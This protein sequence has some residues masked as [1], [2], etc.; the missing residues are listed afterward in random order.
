MS[1]IKKQFIRNTCSGWLAQVSAAVVG[2]IMLPYNL[3]HLGKDVYGISVIAVSAIAMLQ[4]LNLGMGPA[5]LR[6][7]SQAI[8]RKDKN[9]IAVISST[10]Q[11]I[12]GGLGLL[13]S[14]I[15]IAGIPWF[16]RFYEIAQENHHETSILL[17]C[18]AVT[19]FQGFHQVVFSSIVT[20]S[21][22]FDMIYLNSII[23]NWLRMGLLILFYQIFPPSLICLSMALILASTFN[24]LVITWLA[25]REQGR[26]IFFSS[27][28]VAL[29][30]FP[31]L[32]SFS[33]LIMIS[34]LFGT[35]AS[36]VPIMIIGKTMGKETVAVFYPVVL[37]ATSLHA[38]LDQ[39]AVSLVPIA[40]RDKIN[41][42]G[43]NL[44]RWA[45][46]LGQVVACIGYACICISVLFLPNVIRLWL[47]NDFVGITPLAIVMVCGYVYGNIQSIN[48]RLAL[49]TATI[50]PYVCSDGIIAFIVS[51]GTLIGTV[52]LG[53]G[54][55]E[56]C[57]CIALARIVCYTFYPSWVY[58]RVFSYN[59]YHYFFVIYVK[60]IIPS[61]LVLAMLWLIQYYVFRNSLSI[62]ISMFEGILFSVL[63]CVVSWFLIFTRETKSL[64]RL[65]R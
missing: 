41:N 65:N 11:V 16:L 27:K 20:A 31:S 57:L 29:S 21:H 3:H 30:W 34:G 44:G 35:I 42:G 17:I 24:Y 58:S 19:F 33:F 56:I 36:Q 50:I 45:V 53:W 32:F 47:G 40:S 18:F 48:Y 55:W 8:V 23:S 7:F 49:G 60:P 14:I 28:K 52:Y 59:F 13:G 64:V 43:K 4:F 12:I 38:I 2:F 25:F 10:S 54:T 46:S 1:N 39:F 9:E 26:C 63:Y 51:I 37:I 15:I 61:T 5:L 62:F 6:F 22:R